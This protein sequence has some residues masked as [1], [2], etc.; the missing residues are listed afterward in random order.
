MTK[1]HPEAIV[2]L[3][4]PATGAYSRDVLLISDDGTKSMPKGGVCKDALETAK[5][6]RALKAEVP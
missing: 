2:P 3:K 5:S 4:D 6:F 1:F